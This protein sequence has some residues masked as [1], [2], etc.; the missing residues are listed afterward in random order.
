MITKDS[1]SNIVQILAHNLHMLVPTTYP[2]FSSWSCVDLAAQQIKV[3]W[4]SIFH[5]KL[6][7]KSVYMLC[8]SYSSSHTEHNKIRFAIF[9]FFYDLI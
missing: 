3:N 1:F 4:F 8:R 7:L 2:K 9:G 6:K 5:V